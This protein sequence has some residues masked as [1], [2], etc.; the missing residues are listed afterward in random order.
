MNV[1]L[2][3]QSALGLIS[4]QQP[5]F[6]KKPADERVAARALEGCFEKIN[7]A[8]VMIDRERTG[9]QSSPTGALSQTVD[10]KSEV[11]F[12]GAFR[13]SFAHPEL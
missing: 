2:R 4:A 3:P 5:D 6:I 9:R 8:L 10:C 7:H 12:R 11:R 13:K 1:G